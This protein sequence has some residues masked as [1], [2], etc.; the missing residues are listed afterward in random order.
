MNDPSEYPN[1]KP[2]R[3]L[4][5]S[6]E[7]KE[8]K[9]RLK[10]LAKRKGPLWFGQKLTVNELIA[11]LSWE[12]LNCGMNKEAL[13]LAATM[14]VR[15]YGY[16][17]CLCIGRALTSLERFEQARVVL[18]KG[19]ERYPDNETLLIAMG[20]CLGD[21]EDHT[22][23]LEFFDKALAMRPRCTAALN[24]KADALHR[25]GY[26][27]ESLAI[28]EKLLKHSPS[29]P[30]YLTGA[31]NCHLAMGYPDK[32]MESYQKSIK[33]KYA[34][35]EVYNGL[36]WA[37]LEQGFTTNA[38]EIARKSVTRFPDQEPI[39]YRDLACVYLRMEWNVEARATIEKGLEIFPGNEYLVEL[40]KDMDDDENDPDNGVNPEVKP[41]IVVLKNEREK[42][43]KAALR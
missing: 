35:P 6:R 30:L 41:F 33:D 38:L 9:A 34:G 21:Q 8:A 1:A 27:E 42:G 39:L 4:R 31:G 36:C 5:L 40:D 11:D 15:G 2:R 12:L 20:N 17:R 32:A 13:A 3:V 24:N 19:I 16:H 10:T 14:P 37:Y 29:R 7:L 25:L 26:Y 22:G 43:R 18:E 23:S 28:Y